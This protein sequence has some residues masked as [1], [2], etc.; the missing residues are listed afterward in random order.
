MTVR[1][2]IAPSPTGDPHVGTAYIGLLNWCFAR[3]HGGKFILRIE[4]T[5][6]TRCTEASAQ[7]IYRSLKWLGLDYDEGPD[8]GGDRGPYVQSERVQLGIY[9][10]YAQQLIDQGDAYPCFC[11]SHD[12]EAMRKAQV[13]AGGALGYDR[14]CRDLPPAEAAARIARGDA[15]V[16]RMKTPLEGDFVYKDRL[17]AKPVVKA[18][19]EIDD[20][21]LLKSDG[22][23]TYHL[24]AVVDDH[25]MGITHVIRAEEWLNSLSK[26]IW[27]NQH[28]G[29]APPEYVHVGLLRNA[30]KSK[31]SKRKNPTSLLWYQRQGYLPEA[32]L[33][34][35][36]LLGHS[37]PDGKEQFPLAEMAAFFD[38]DRINVAGPVFDLKK[39]DHLQGLWFRQLPPERVRDEVVRAIDTRFAELYPML[40]E[41]M[42]RGGDFLTQAEPFY[43]VAVHHHL[44]DLLPKGV[45]K[46]QARL[47]LEAFLKAFQEHQKADGAWTAPALES[48]VRGVCE[49]RTAAEP[50]QAALWSPKAAFSLL[51][52]AATGRRES[53]PLF[54]TAAAIGATRVQERLAAA[55][56]KLR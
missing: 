26:H 10:R 2:R 40:R 31:I 37:H 28:L 7:A 44:D 36:G 6:R 22:W 43:A 45:E 1:V 51:R 8:V 54:E 23:P 49:A 41:R 19:K 15:H 29:F 34:F 24:A 33:N 9:R 32:L 12:L 47:V 25:L 42:V 39:L 3:R 5:D 13:A 17:R 30:D 46:D 4:D 35:L 27:L 20:Q 52:A 38:L 50:A 48:L 16:I 21:V 14:R 53:P 11:T 18:W 55:V 56:Q